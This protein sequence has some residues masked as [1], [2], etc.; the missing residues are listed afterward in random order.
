MSHEVE[1]IDIFSLTHDVKRITTKKPEGYQFRP[2][3]ATE[4]AI[5]LPGFEDKKRPFTFTSLPEDD[6]LEFVIKS[7][8]D[9]NGVTK[10]IEGLVEGN[11]LIIGDAW[12]AIQYKGRGT[13]IAGGAGITP[14]ISILRYLERKGDLVGHSLYFSNKTGKDVIMESDLQEMMKDNFVSV[15]TREEVEGHEHGR[16]DMEF[17]KNHIEDYSQNFYVCGP[18]KMVKDINELLE[19]LGANAD[20]LVFEK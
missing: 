3:Q 4:V 15:L 7:Y 6:H 1:I 16:I 5:N 9:H 10:A 17:L 20:A 14:F 8:R 19:K 12:G 18:K 13:F 2:G 11:S